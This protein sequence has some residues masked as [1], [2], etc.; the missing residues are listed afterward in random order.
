M[1]VWNKKSYA[2]KNNLY[3]EEWL[4]TY[5]EKLYFKCR[6]LKKDGKI[7]E[8]FTESGEI[9]IIVSKGDGE[10]EVKNVWSDKELEQF[11]N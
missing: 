9:K 8:V 7:K 1:E 10:T 2:K 4:T 11:E 6:Q 5:R 3:M